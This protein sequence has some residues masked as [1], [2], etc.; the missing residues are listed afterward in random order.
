[1]KQIMGT[2]A[3]AVLFLAPFQTRAAKAVKA[4]KVIVDVYY[5]HGNQR[6]MSCMKIEAYTKEAVEQKFSADIK[7]NRVVMHVVNLDTPGNE[8]YIQDFKINAKTVVVT[9][10]VGG[11]LESFQKL[12][13]VWMLLRDKPKFLSY[14]EKSVNAAKKAE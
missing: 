4:P 6:C 13:Q 11:K 10:S 5:F 2:L 8:H 9:R 14:V 12:D 7:K 1:M 3:L